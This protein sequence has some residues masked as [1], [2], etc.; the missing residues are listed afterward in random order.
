[1]LSTLSSTLSNTPSS[2]HNTVKIVI[3]ARY[4]ST[5]LVGKPLRLL[6]GKPMIEH[7][8]HCAKRANLG[9]IIIA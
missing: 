8:Y 3:P 1:M 9:D 6:A 4:A 2:N 7:V 5:R